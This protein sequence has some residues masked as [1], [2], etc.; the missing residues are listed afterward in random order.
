MALEKYPYNQ[1]L[2]GAGTVG[3]SGSCSWH[4]VKACAEEPTSSYLTPIGRM[5][6]CPRAERQIEDRYGSPS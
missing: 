4:G 6:A 2:H 1:S 3:H 5:A